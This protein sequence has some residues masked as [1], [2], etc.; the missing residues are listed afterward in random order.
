[1]KIAVCFSGQPRSLPLAA[2]FAVDSV[3]EPNNVDSVFV[4]SWFC[5]TVTNQSFGTAQP[6]QAG[7][8]GGYNPDTP[9]ILTS[10][11]KPK[12]ILLERP[13]DFKQFAHLPGP[14]Q[15]VQ[16]HLASMYYSAWQANELKKEYEKTNNIVFDVVVK[17][18]IDLRY[19]EPLLLSNIVDGDLEDTIYVAEVHNIMR[20]NDSYP[21][22]SGGSYSSLSDTLIVGSSKNMD[23]MC[24]VYP[25]FENYYNAIHPFSYGECYVGYA[26]HIHGLK[27]KMKHMNYK[28]HRG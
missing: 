14:E 11:L 16:S 20:I 8:L 25:N 18:R 27:V 7:T 22:S 13:H 15:A 26:R 24:D 10:K 19:L 28:I 21:I 9:S 12:K 4:H 17:T 5:P 6:W 1:M 3:L 2:D 23:K